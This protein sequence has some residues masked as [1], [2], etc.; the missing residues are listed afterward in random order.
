MKAKKT[1]VVTVMMLVVSM[2]V[3]QA[4]ARRGRV[5]FGVGYGHRVH[6]PYRFHAGYAF[7]GP[8]LIRVGRVNYGAVDFNVRPQKS[9]IYVDGGFLGIADDF[10]GYP[11]TAK[12]PVGTHNIRVVAPDGREVVRRIYVAPGQEVNFNLKF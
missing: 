12:L 1:L 10:N 5:G 11:Q 6:H 3:S 9:E 7:R 8:A 4:T 2:L